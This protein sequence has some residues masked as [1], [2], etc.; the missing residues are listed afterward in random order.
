MPF[1]KGREEQRNREFS[2]GEKEREFPGQQLS[3]RSKSHLQIR[4]V[5]F[6]KAQSALQA[7]LALRVVFRM[8]TL[9]FFFWLLQKC[10]NQIVGN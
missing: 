7:V 10:K 6:T 9:F 3:S 1:A 8:E 5:L 4:V 2:I